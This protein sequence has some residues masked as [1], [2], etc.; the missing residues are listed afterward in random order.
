[1]IH[2]FISEWAAAPALILKRDGSVR[3]CIDYHALNEVS[4]IQFPT[5]PGG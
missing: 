3:W 1:M 2:E 4:E 5:A